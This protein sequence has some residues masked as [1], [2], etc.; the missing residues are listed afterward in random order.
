MSRANLPAGYRKECRRSLQ[1]N[2]TERLLA[3][4]LEVPPW[5]AEIILAQ[6][7]PLVCVKLVKPAYRRVHKTLRERAAGRS[8][9]E[10]PEFLRSFSNSR[11]SLLQ[12]ALDDQLLRVVDRL[13]TRS[14]IELCEFYGREVNDTI[15]LLRNLYNGGK[16][17]RT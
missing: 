17:P 6:L 12:T 14:L 3:H 16:K 7:R 4:L 10:I 1:K 9:T 15:S 11:E 13:P 8:L 2:R 5:Y